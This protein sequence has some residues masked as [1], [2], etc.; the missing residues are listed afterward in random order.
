MYREIVFSGYSWQ[1]KASTVPVG[2]GPNYFSDRE[3]DVW[4]DDQGRLHLRIA[5]HESRW[6][7]TEVIADASLGYGT[8]VFRLTGR[9][10]QYDPY[11][12]LGLFTWDTGAPEHYYREIDVEFSR[13]G[14]PA[15]AN[16][17][18]VVQ[19]WTTAGNLYRF[20]FAPSGDRST[21]C[22]EWAPDQVEFKSYDGFVDCPG[23]GEGAAGSWVYTGPD[24]PP[25]GAENPR[26]NLWL[27][28]GTPPGD[29]QSIEVMIEEF[30]FVP[31]S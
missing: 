19:P 29:G 27:N 24:I 23:S 20:E 4:V 1:V 16:A 25:P 17:Q 30:G 5:E 3:E 31:A 2:P 8:Y 18:Y 9:L 26:I 13:W 7:S 11:V 14:D 22:F 15:A 21:H 10:E 6:Y 12:V 28:E